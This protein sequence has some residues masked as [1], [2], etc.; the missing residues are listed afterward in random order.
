MGGGGADVEGLGPDDGGHRAQSGGHGSHCCDRQLHAERAV[1]PEGH[2]G[3]HHASR[4][5]VIP[6]L[7]LFKFMLPGS[8]HFAE[9]FVDCFLYLDCAMDLQ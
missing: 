1:P 9:Q 6:L 5:L 2:S 8:S 7:D 4:H 3:C